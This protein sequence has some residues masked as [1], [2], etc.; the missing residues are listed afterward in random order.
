MFVRFTNWVKVVTNKLLYVVSHPGVLWKEY[1]EEVR[2]RVWARN[3]A[4][5][6]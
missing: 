6:K 2:A 3:V 4:K 1:R 5:N